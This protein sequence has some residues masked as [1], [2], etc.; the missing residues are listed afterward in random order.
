[1]GVRYVGVEVSDINS[2]HDAV[3]RNRLGERP[4]DL[5]EEVGV[6]NEG[7]E[8]CDDGYDVGVGLR[9][10]T[11]VMSTESSLVGVALVPYFQ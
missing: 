10:D 5:K 3:G 11:P 1:M 7:G 2:R 4:N 9:R 8:G 6:V